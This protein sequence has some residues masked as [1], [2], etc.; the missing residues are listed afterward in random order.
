[1]SEVVIIF[2]R[3]YSNTEANGFLR[4]FTK[5]CFAV[6]TTLLLIWVFITPR[7]FISTN[8]DE[9][10]A[11]HQGF[12][13]PEIELALIAGGKAS[14]QDYSGKIVL[15]NFWASWC[16]PCRSEMPAMQQVY[17][18]YRDEGLEVVAVNMTHQDSLSDVQ[19]F[20]NIYQLTFP[21][22]LDMRGESALKYQVRALPTTFLIDRAGVIREVVVGGP[23]TKAFL[24][25]KIKQLLEE[26]N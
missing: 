7:L 20:L 21:V 26:V 23:L 17:E 22:M 13:A 8:S 11:P 1:M 25:V 24:E 2:I 5:I 3:F 6:L 19:S 4:T 14:L 18:S 15:L 16:P 10:A 12:L 9:V